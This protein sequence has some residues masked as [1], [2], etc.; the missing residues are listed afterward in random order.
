MLAFNLNSQ[1]GI[2]KAICGSPGTT[3][4]SA[5]DVKYNSSVTQQAS[6]QIQGE[7]RRKKNDD[8][9]RYPM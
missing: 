1:A 3:T 7:I 5:C 9:I 6:E 8:C 4:K 2:C